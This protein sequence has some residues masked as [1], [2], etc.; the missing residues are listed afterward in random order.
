[1]GAV[2]LCLAF[3][4]FYDITSEA[5]YQAWR[6]IMKEWVETI[7]KSIDRN[8]AIMERFVLALERVAGIPELDHAPPVNVSADQVA[9]TRDKSL[10]DMSAVDFLKE[11]ANKGMLSKSQHTRLKHIVEATPFL[12]D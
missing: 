7:V 10:R 12:A 9:L 1:M 2:Y 11:A 6:E 4:E 5:F 8:T 3:L